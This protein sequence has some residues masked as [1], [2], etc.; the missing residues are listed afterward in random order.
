MTTTIKGSVWMSRDGALNGHGTGHEVEVEV[1]N[2]SVLSRYRLPVLRVGDRDYGP[3]ERIADGYLSGHL[4]SNIVVELWVSLGR[5]LAPIDAQRFLA[6][7]IEQWPE[8]PRRFTPV[9]LVAGAAD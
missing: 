7:F 1:T 8:A 5:G 3:S 4:A 6:R 2:D 9:D